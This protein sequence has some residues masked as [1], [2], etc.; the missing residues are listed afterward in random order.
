VEAGR[1]LRW[2]DTPGNRA[3]VVA[4]VL[5]ALRAPVSRA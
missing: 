3:V 5:A 1:A 2:Q 4:L